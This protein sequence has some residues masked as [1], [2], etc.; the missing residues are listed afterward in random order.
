LARNY[1]ATVEAPRCHPQHCTAEPTARGQ[2][3][4]VWSDSPLGGTAMYACPISLASLHS[5]PY[6]RVRAQD[7]SNEPCMVCLEDLAPTR[8]PHEPD[9]TTSASDRSSIDVD[10]DQERARVCVA[11]KA[12]A[13]QY[14]EGCLAAALANSMA[15]AICRAPVAQ[16]MRGTQPSGTMQY[17]M[18]P[19]SAGM[20]QQ[21]HPSPGVK[22][23]GAR[24]IAYLPDNRD[25][26]M[27]LNRLLY[28]FEHGLTFTVGTSYTSGQP[29]QVTWGT[30]QTRYAFD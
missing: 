5:N 29:N 7:I 16:G 12:C 10:G 28:A 2:P 8:M 14:H 23:Q 11:L 1:S 13:H 15:C 25:R 6:Q 21:Y 3:A 30:N 26:K 18:Y 22:H 17:K 27:L 24:R 9:T 20:Q 4:P 19:F